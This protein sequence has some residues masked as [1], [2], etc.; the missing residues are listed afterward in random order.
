MINF[1][2]ARLIVKLQ[3][4]PTW[5]SLKGTFHVAD[6]GSE[7]D[8]YFSVNV[9]AREFLVDNNEE[10]AEYSGVLHLVDKVTG[11]YLRGSF[12]DFDQLESFVPIGDVP[13]R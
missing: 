1:E 8:Q 10:F 12:L 6:W 9:G 4:E 5:S 13:R 2:E 3:I 7:N 11:L